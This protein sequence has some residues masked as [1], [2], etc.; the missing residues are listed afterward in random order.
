[1]LAQA[2]VTP[3]ALQHPYTNLPSLIFALQIPIGR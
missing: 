1:M 2:T 3:E